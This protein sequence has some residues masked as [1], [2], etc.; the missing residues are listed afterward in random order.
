MH[1]VVMQVMYYFLGKVLVLQP[2]PQ[3]KFVQEP[4][5]PMLPEG[6]GL[7]TLREPT[8]VEPAVNPAPPEVREGA[9]SVSTSHIGNISPASSLSLTKR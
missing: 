3:L 2:D 1:V 9:T 6:P 5:H 4:G 7:Y 8:L